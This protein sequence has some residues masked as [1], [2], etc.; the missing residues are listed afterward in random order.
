[1]LEELRKL[2]AENVIL[3]T[4]IMVRRDGLPYA[5]GQPR[6][7]DPGVAVYWTRKGK[8]QVMA[9]DRWATIRDNMHAIGLT[10]NA[11]RAITR[12]GSS[13]LL[14]RAFTGY[15]ALPS[16]SVVPPWQTVLFPEGLAYPYDHAKIEARYKELVLK[17]HPDQGGDHEKFLEL[18]RAYEQA[19]EELGA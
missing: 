13:E 2:G 9:C 4:N 12:A 6:V 16:G 19:L 1:M 8:Q 3:S 14:D 7:T 11:M 15:D 10:I 5:S 18:Q 17:T